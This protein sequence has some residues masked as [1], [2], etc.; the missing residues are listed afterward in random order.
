MS[1]LS[2]VGSLSDALLVQVI[3]PNEKTETI[4][5]VLFYLPPLPSQIYLLSAGCIDANVVYYKRY[6]E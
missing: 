4:E 6:K 1:L 2:I 5:G 3:F